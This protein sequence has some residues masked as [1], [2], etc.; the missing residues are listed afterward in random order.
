MKNK[1]KRQFIKGIAVIAI[2][3]MNGLSMAACFVSIC[4]L[5]TFCAEKA[6]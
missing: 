6:K 2:T 4:G 3:V 1:Q 5:V